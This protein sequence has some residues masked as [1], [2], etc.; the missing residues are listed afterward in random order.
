MKS[1]ILKLQ[2]DCEIFMNSPE[3]RKLSR[4]ELLEM[5]VDLAKENEEL[6]EELEKTR[7][8]LESKRI[9]IA[10]AGDIAEASLRLNKVFE[11]AR[12]AASQY[13]ANIKVLEKQ[14]QLEIEKIRELRE[15][16]DGTE[17]QQQS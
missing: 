11:A 8:E 14:K 6:K 15:K 3:L 12:D 4:E 17:S 9:R 7:K 10:K 13:V 5:L 1:G 2:S 16:L